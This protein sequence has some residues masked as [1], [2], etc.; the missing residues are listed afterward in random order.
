MENQKLKI[1]KQIETGLMLFFST[2]MYRSLKVQIFKYLFIL[3]LRRSFMTV[4]RV[5]S[6][7]HWGQELDYNRLNRYKKLRKECGKV[8]QQVK[9]RK[10]E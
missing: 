2:G 10:W 7:K 6:V 9:V 8:S 4:L 3:A 1:H 5:T